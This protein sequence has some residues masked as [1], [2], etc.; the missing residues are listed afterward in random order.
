MTRYMLLEHDR[1]AADIAD[2]E[3]RLERAQRGPGLRTRSVRSFLSELSRHKRGMLKDLN[4]R[5]AQT[6][7]V[8]N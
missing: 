6:G 2:L 7:A 4:Q 1:L 3:A 8:L 5:I